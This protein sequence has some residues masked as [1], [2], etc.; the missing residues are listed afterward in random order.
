MTT[1]INRTVSIAP[2]M[3]WTD[4]HFRAFLR[5]ISRE[6]LLY[7]EMVTTPAIMLGDRE[8]LLGFHEPEHPIALQLGGSDPKALAE[9]AKIA[10]DFGYDEVNLNVGCPSDRVQEGR[11][12]ACL[13]KEP[14][15][16]ADCVAAMQ[17]VVDIPVTVKTR[18]GVDEF[19]QEEYLHQFT[20]ACVANGLQTLIVHARKAWL[21]GLNPKQNREIPPLHYDRVYR[22]KQAYPDV[23]IIINGGIR[24]FE[25]MQTHLQHVDGVMIGRAAYQAPQC[26]A[27]VDRDLYDKAGEVASEKQWV[28]RY[29][30]YVISQL[31]NGVPLRRMTKHLIGLFVGKNGARQWRR[32]LSEN[33]YKDHADEQVLLTALGFIAE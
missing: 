2:M 26:L 4:K 3:A 1:A 21:K 13:M 5:S 11:F 28:E 23:E 25:D 27:T 24:S 12:G 20:E 7:T 32:Y 6:M 14:K 10:V 17:A 9:C 18:I 30:P 31:Q 15:L 19:D 33:A 22:L 16:V 29:I 8:R